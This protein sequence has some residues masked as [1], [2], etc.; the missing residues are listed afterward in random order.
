ML[1]RTRTLCLVYAKPGRSLAD[2]QQMYAY[3]WSPQTKCTS[4]GV[5]LLEASPGH[6]PQFSASALRKAMLLLTQ[7]R[8]TSLS[9]LSG[10]IM[11]TDC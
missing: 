1:C 10:A 8:S 3:G 11:T 5:L 6:V 2:A 7:P 4:S 9:Q